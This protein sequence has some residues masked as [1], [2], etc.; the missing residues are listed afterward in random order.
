[1]VVQ[2][3]VLLC[4]PYCS[5]CCYCCG[6]FCKGDR[7][8]AVS[9]AGFSTIFE[10]RQ[11]GTAASSTA[12]AVVTIIVVSQTATNISAS[13]AAAATAEATAVKIKPTAT[14]RT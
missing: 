6:L 8:T 12:A 10:C 3:M 1:M 14:G 5:H 4:H 11:A 13:V 7:F 9:Q 2:L